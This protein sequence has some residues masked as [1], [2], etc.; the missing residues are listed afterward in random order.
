M[1]GRLIKE[2]EIIKEQLAEL[3]E[4]Y[5]NCSFPQMVCDYIRFTGMK[6]EE[7]EELLNEIKM[8]IKLNQYDCKRMN[9][10]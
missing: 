3:L 5:Y 1:M 2:K 6:S 9:T 4:K 8:N 7:V 10:N